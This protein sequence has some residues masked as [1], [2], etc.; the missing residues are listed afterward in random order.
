[1][2]KEVNHNTNDEMNLELDSLQK[3]GYG[4]PTS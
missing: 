2:H 3:L 1:M 4:I